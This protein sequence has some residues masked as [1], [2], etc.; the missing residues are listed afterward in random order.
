MAI[1][2]HKVF[3]LIFFRSCIC[4]QVVFTFRVIIF[5]CTTELQRVQVHRH[6]TRAMIFD[7]NLNGPQA[8]IV[9]RFV[10][11]TQFTLRTFEVDVVVL[12]EAFR[13]LHRRLTILERRLR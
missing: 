4:V 1:D 7:Q 5:F 11:K 13:A 12:V 3:M 10:Q 6:C 9:R 8:I 2:W